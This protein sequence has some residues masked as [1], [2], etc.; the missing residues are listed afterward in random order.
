MEGHSRENVL[1]KIKGDREIGAAYYLGSSEQDS[2]N[3]E[4]ANVPYK[5]EPSS[6]EIEEF[7]TRLRQ[8]G[9]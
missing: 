1:G 3:K 8:E 2:G 7:L 4:E 6:T 5:L 9:L